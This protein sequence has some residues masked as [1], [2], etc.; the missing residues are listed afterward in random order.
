MV[1]IG[2][3]ERG[4]IMLGSL[5]DKILIFA[6]ENIQYTLANIL[7]V[8]AILTSAA[9]LI[10]MFLMSPREAKDVDAKTTHT[11]AETMAAYEEAIRRA[12]ERAE[13]VE[14]RYILLETSINEKQER[15]NQITVERDQ[16]VAQFRT[17]M[18]ALEAEKRRIIAAF[19]AEIE[20]RDRQIRE[21]IDWA[22]RLV[23]QVQS[24]GGEPV[25]LKPGSNPSYRASGPSYG[26]DSQKRSGDPPTARKRK[27]V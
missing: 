11:I 4:E 27:R 18:A 9:G 5:S 13:R 3:P 10:K 14:E 2:S 8:I 6:E 23:H 15:I 7:S 20:D 26:G 21:L 17:Q 12:N 1:S 24:Y 25:P 22:E 16:M 19:E